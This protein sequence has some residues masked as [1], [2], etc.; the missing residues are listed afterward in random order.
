MTIDSRLAAYVERFN[1]T[2]FNHQL[3]GIR[4]LLEKDNFGLFD[5]MGVGKSAQVVNAACILSEER[6]IDTVLVVSP[7]SVRSVWTN[8]DRDLGEISKHSWASADVM[9]FH[10]RGLRG[11]FQRVCSG[12]RPLTWVVTNYEFIR[13]AKNRDRLIATLGGRP[14]LMVLDESSMIK[15]HRAIQTK[16]CLQIGLHAAR[17]VILNGTPITN[18]PGDLW[19]QM[20]FLSPQILPFKN[21]F[22]F[23]ARYAVMGGWQNKQIVQWVNLEELQDRVR[24]WVLRREKKDCLD[25]PEKTYTQVEVPLTPE[26]WERYKSM[27]DEAIAWFGENPS[28]AAQAGVKAMRLAQLTSGVLG[29]VEGE[30]DAC[31]VSYEKF[32]FL[33]CWVIERLEENPYFKVIVWSRFRPQLDLI[34]EKLAEVI[35]T[36]RLCGGQSHAEREAAKLPFMRPTREAALLSAQPH[37]G[38][39]GLNLVQANTVVYASNDHALGSRLQSED[40]VHRPGQN[41]NVLYI[42]VMATGPKGQRT[43]DHVIVKNLRKKQDLANWTASAWKEA[44]VDE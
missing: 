15:N 38:G 8:E 11:V 13:P 18:S 35:P 41:R 4:M 26:S 6:V 40:R 1:M 12:T 44:L 25:L 17:R 24:P 30:E 20:R 22:S 5:E 34:Y 2:P 42:D 10:S 21:F 7:A 28:A 9:E 37:A 36:Y 27:R 23:R 31:L 16:S 14:F 43:V 29:G 32:E 39:F 19:S 33:R 3:D